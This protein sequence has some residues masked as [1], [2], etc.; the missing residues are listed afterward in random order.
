MG[1]IDD[2]K[3]IFGDIAALNTV[4]DGLP[5]FNKNSS[6]ES[7]N[8]EKDSMKF[9]SD[10]LVVLAELNA[11]KKIIVDI[12]TFQLPRLEEE[13]KE[14][15]KESIKENCGC[16]INPSI[17]DYFKSTGNGISVSVK[18]ID[19]F[20][21][22]KVDPTTFEGGLTYSD[23]GAGT[24]SK[25]FNTYLNST[26]QNP[27]N[28][29]AFGSSISGSDIIDTKFEETNANGDNNILTFN[30]N[31][32]YD[33]GKSLVD[34]NNNFVD[35]IS[36]FGNP[37]VL[38]SKVI[39]NLIM[40]EL[41]SSFSSSSGVNKSKE[42]IK[43]EVEVKKVLQKIIESDD[44][45]ENGAYKFNNNELSEISR[46]VSNRKEGILETRCCEQE[47]LTI[48]NEFLSTIN[49]NFD[50]LDLGNKAEELAA[51]EDS[52][53]SLADNQAKQ[54]SD[55]SDSESIKY[56]FFKEIID[57]LMLILITQIISPKFTALLMV[58]FTISNGGVTP[59]YDSAIDLIKEN[60]NIF[61]DVRKRIYQSVIAIVLIFALR[62]YIKKL[63]KK[64]VGD[65][66]EQAQNYARML[67]S[68]L[69]ISAEYKN[70]LSNLI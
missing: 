22:M 46:E 42:Q 61:K 4:N 33:T 27:G 43:K 20:D 52:L 53:G 54:A 48:S 55:S 5:K 66:I 26:I 6:L 63:L 7:S 36:L 29:E 60:E 65:K 19:F 39:L 67:F 47:K 49:E 31:Q 30:A 18:N 8:N 16:N 64:K 13:I 50:I 15:L 69:P 68:Y 3:E 12:I 44:S 23:V 57:K 24:N 1:L 41:F 62:L 32:N 34:F 21:I 10:V 11:L 2:K 17:P 9:L 38:N 56:N 40:E 51:V 35:S 28:T 45:I 59:Q 58:N 37:D 70:I 25:D 14:A